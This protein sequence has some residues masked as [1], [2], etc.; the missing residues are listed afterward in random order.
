MFTPSLKNVYLAIKHNCAY[1]VV[2]FFPASFLSPAYFAVKLTK[3]TLEFA[4][5]IVLG[6]LCSGNLFHCISLSQVGCPVSK[7]LTNEKKKND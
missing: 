4:S 1:S 5:E 2:F 7:L 3:L 6:D